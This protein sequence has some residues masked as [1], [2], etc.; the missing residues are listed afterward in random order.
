MT[1]LA[2]HNRTFYFS[3]TGLAVDLNGPYANSGAA[4][5]LTLVELDSAGVVTEAAGA[6]VEGPGVLSLQL[7]TVGQFIFNGANTFSGGVFIA[8][9]TRVSVG[10]SGAL[11]TG[12]ITFLAGA[13]TPALESLATNFSTAQSIEI[14][15]GVSATLEAA[16]G[17]TLT[18]TGVLNDAGGQGTTLHIGSATDTGTVVLSASA[19]TQ[20]AAG[21]LS[22][23]GGTL[24]IGSAASAQMISGL[25]GGV[26]VKGTLDLGGQNLTANKLSGGGRIVNSGAAATLKVAEA[27]Q[28]ALGASISGSIA[29]EL[30]AGAFTL[31]GANSYTGGT[32]IDAG[33]ELD[34]GDGATPGAIAGN[35]IDNGA[36][37]FNLRGLV[38]F[39]GSLSGSGSLWQTGG[40][41]RLT[42]DASQFAGQATLS[43]GTTTLVGA[44]AFSKIASLSLGN[45]ET[46]RAIANVT[47]S[48]PLSLGTSNSFGSVTVSAA[49]NKTLNYTGAFGA[50]PNVGVI[51]HIGSATDTGVVILANAGSTGFNGRVGFAIDGGTLVTPSGLFIGSVAFTGTTGKLIVSNSSQTDASSG[52]GSTGEV[53]LNSSQV[54]FRGGGETVKFV[55]GSNNAATLFNTGSLWDNVYG[56]GG[57]VTLGAA[58]A[59]IVGG[60]DTVNFTGS[61]PSAASLFNTAGN[62]DTVN[63]VGVVNLTNAQA[64]VFNGGVTVNLL[65]AAPNSVSFYNGNNVWD[66]VNGS[67]GTISLTASCAS[68][69]GG[70][71]IVNLLGNGD[72]ASLYNTNNA[73][74]TVNGSNGLVILTNAQ[75]TVVGGGDTINFDGSANDAVTL[76]GTNF[77]GDTVNAVNGS[78]TLDSALAAIVGY[79]NTIHMNGASVAIETLTNS[80][81]RDTYVYQ[82]ASGDSAIAG[83]TSHDAMQLAQ[84]QFG[85]VQNLFDNF[86]SQSGANTII[87]L[88]ASDQITLLNVQKASL[89]QSQFS[90]T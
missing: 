35:V 69:V 2:G 87:T 14:G 13:T 23:D 83:F 1:D 64:S 55:S 58:R 30:A 37:R 27:A 4:A 56:S 29:L 28:T 71:D 12:A 68:I 36:L 80:A 32:T 20:D 44:N 90:L 67:N 48:A 70:G 54:T 60:G 22:I 42:G 82:Q 81:S 31:T 10:A 15:A 17:D 76:S 45:F 40:N 53:D 34:A 26:T 89:S 21:A 25:Q 19:A 5:L 61:A 51:L 46:F 50:A 79:N 84:A 86:M 3:N 85:T 57:T 77:N 75:A 52:A 72:T 78:I 24:R 47:I 41:L 33:A 66:T 18:V 11:G 8:G 74:D 9:S 65:G 6:I 62:A 16:A 39:T 73:S 43:A 59:S 49:A 88:D 63:G 38:N 7:A